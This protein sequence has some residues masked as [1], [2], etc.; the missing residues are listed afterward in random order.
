AR[1]QI[2]RALERYVPDVEATVEREHWTRLRSELQEYWDA[3]MP[4]LAAEPTRNPAQA[5]AVLNN[6]VIPKRRTII[7]ISEQ[8]RTLNKDAFQRQEAAIARL[9]RDLR[10]QIWALSGVALVLGVGVAFGATRYAGGL[11]SRIRAQHSADV[12]RKREL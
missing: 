3:T 4:V 12:E 2:D 7:E 10:S 1:T 6:Q 9:Y 11:E 5:L 8:L